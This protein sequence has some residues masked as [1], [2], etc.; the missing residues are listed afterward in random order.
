GG[1]KP[2]ALA[3]S[4]SPL[5][6]EEAADLVAAL[7]EAPFLEDGMHA[8]LLARAGGN[9][10]YAEQYARMLNERGV[11]E[12]VPETVQGIIAAR[13][14]GLPEGEKRLLQDA[15]V[16]GKVFWLGA[17]EAVDGITRWEAE[18]LLHTLE[19]KEFVRRSRTSS[20]ATETEYAFRH[21]LIRDIAYGQIPRASRSHRHRRAAGWIESL[22][23]PE[24]Q[25][26]MLAHH[27]LRALELAQAAGLDSSQL[28]EPARRALR[29]AGDRA[30]ALY[31][32]EAAERF[33]DDALRLWPPD[34]PERAELLFR[35]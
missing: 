11:L 31:A 19:R 5:S 21:L 23:R 26:E 4:L 3:I 15:A 18:E 12:E 9:P 30:A 28:A 1:G 2:N 17:V 32:A 22:G 35:R 14:D 20:V 34:A 24:E 7:L 8:E 29:D 33:Y 25:A 13:L 6:D 16:I 10:L 27:Y